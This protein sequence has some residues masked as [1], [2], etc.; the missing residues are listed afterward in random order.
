MEAFLF[1]ISGPA[2]VCRYIYVDD[3][4]VVFTFCLNVPPD[5]SG[6]HPP[7]KL[8]SPRLPYQPARNRKYIY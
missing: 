6:F 4:S 2:T 5:Y 8:T 1:A 7:P 3:V